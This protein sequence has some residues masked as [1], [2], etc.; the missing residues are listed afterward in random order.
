MIITRKI[1]I[2]VNEDDK[3]KRKEYYDKLFSWLHICR[4][5][6]NILSSHLFTLDNIKNMIY[7][8]EETKVKLA[9]IAKDESGI[10]NTSYQNS[11][12]R[13]LSKL[14]KG[15]IPT[16]IL[17]NLNN[18]VNKT[19][20]EEKIEYFTGKRSLRNYKTNIP[21][22]FSSRKAKIG[23]N[24][25]GK[26][27][28]TIH[29]IPFTLAFGRDRSGNKTIVDRVMEGEYKMSNSSIA[30]D[31]RKNKWF[32]LLCVN[33]PNSRLKGKPGVEVEA[34]LDID[35]PIIARCGK[36]TDEIGNKEEYLYQRV[37]IQQKLTRL[38]KSLRY[39]SG[40]RG[41]EAKLQAIE[42]FHK[43]ERNYAMTK[44]HTYSRLLV[45]FAVKM[46]AEKIILISTDIEKEP[47]TDEEKFILRN[48]GYY[49]LEQLV[50][51]KAKMAGIETETQK[52]S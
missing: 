30:H 20:K 7:L 16:D 11:G 42:R 14:Y 24:E 38:Q 1:Q 52:R 29:S 51:Y 35:V 5:S 26:Y 36:K 33:I 9:D 34:N 6:A 22:P 18:N 17:T 19:Y 48:W 39:A 12:Y 41:R 21:M 23:K 8:S 40:G 2:L 47:Q 25:A 27:F 31:K 15:H 32:L 4:E 45:N 43:K 50:S 37:Q 46:R 3:G 49:G 13:L 10:L 28:F 44:L